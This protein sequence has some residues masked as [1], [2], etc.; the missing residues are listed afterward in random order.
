MASQVVKELDDGLLSGNS[1]LNASLV[2]AVQVEVNAVI[3][4]LDEGIGEILEVSFWDEALLLDIL[5]CLLEGDSEVGD[6][7]EAALSA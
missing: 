5:D 7:D 3:K 1:S 2:R 4:E 6:V